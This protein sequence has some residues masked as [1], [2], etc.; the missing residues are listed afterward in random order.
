DGVGG[1]EP[2]ARRK[3]GLGEVVAEGGAARPAGGT[4]VRE[5]EAVLD[6]SQQAVVVLRDARPEAA[7]HPGRDDQRGDASAPGVAATTGATRA[8]VPGDKQRAAVAKRG[9][10][11]DRRDDTAQPAIAG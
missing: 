6:R 10:S 9:G 1:G 11:R 8:L 4:E 2:T 7:D 5:M 3:A